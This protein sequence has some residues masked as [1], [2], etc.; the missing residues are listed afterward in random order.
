MHLQRWILNVQ[1]AV[2]SIKVPFI[3]FITGA[4]GVGKTALV[5]EIE[6]KYGDRNEWKFLH[7]DS[8]GVPSIAEMNEQYGSPS[9]W[10][11]AMTYKWIDKILNEYRHKMM[12]IL[13]GQVNIEFIQNGFS[14]YKFNNYK[15]VHIDCGEDEVC[16]RLTHKRDQPELLS[17]DMKNWL[18]FLR[19]QAMRGGRGRWSC[20]ESRLYSFYEVT[21]YIFSLLG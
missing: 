6:K 7:F 8:I 10:Q 14:K 21:E 11:E 13:E 20:A 4:S 19:K 17:D 5:D 3:C 9:K 2:W 12:V 15:I 1:K 16:Y 18:K